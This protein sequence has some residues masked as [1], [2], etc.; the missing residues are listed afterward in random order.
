[1]LVICIFRWLFP[2]LIIVLRDWARDSMTS[3]LKYLPSEPVTILCLPLLCICCTW[4]HD[5]FCYHVTFLLPQ[6]VLREPGKAS[7]HWLG[8]SSKAFQCWA[9]SAVS[10]QGSVLQQC[11]SRGPCGGLLCYAYPLPQPR[12]CWELSWRLLGTHVHS[13]LISVPCS[14][15]CSRL[16]ALSFT[17]CLFCP[18]DSYALL[19]LH[20]LATM[21][22]KVFQ[23]KEP[24]WTCCSLCGLPF[25]QGS[26][27]CAAWCPMSENN[28]HI[29][30]SFVVIYGRMTS[31]K[32]V[33]INVTRGRSFS[34]FLF[35]S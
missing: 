33:A 31:L 29:Y 6:E 8:W 4:A 27:P 5:D 25:S 24:G 28:C 9:V 34:V 21:V 20:L 2:C 1:M 17:L 19:G 13:S 23:S 15:H 10:F 26:Q 14:T 11:L 35:Y 7:R 12:I 32:L 30:L 3:S 18:E 16:A 22:W